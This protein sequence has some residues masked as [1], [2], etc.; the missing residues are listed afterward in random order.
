M[1]RAASMTGVFSNPLQAG[2]ETDFWSRPLHDPAQ[3]QAQ[4]PQAPIADPFQT[5]QQ[6]QVQPQPQQNPFGGPV[7]TTPIQQQPVQQQPTQQDPDSQEQLRQLQAEINSMRSQ[8]AAAE[9]QRRYEEEQRKAR[10]ER[11]KALTSGMQQIDSR[12]DWDDDQK[13]AA[14][15]VLQQTFDQVNGQVEQE[16]RQYGERVQ[17]VFQ[18]LTGPLYVAQTLQQAGLPISMMNTVMELGIPPQNLP[19][20]IPA[21]KRMAA[22]EQQR[23]QAQA[24]QAN[25]QS[26][27]T[28]INQVPGYGDSAP[29]GQAVEKGTTEHLAQLLVGF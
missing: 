20:A 4:Q 7:E 3:Q 15:Q 10:E 11:R 22:E 13:K 16:F 23:T 29:T 12:D 26:A 1:D 8:Q 24:S 27:Q 2:E 18:N 21:L 9:N 6:P 14:K 5:E 28:G 19:Q 17:G 25:A